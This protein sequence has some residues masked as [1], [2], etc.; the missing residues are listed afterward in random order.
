MEAG[1]NEV[2]DTGVVSKM[3]LNYV[4]AGMGET[5]ETSPSLLGGE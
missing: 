2:K 4:V 1:E 3:G 5:K